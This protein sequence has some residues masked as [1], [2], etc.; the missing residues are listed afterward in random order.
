MAIPFSIAI[1]IDQKPRGVMMKYLI[2]ML[3][4]AA[5]SSKSTQL[6]KKAQNLEVY[7]NKPVDCRVSGRVVGVDKMGSK[8][9]ALND[10]LNQA[11]DLNATGLFV[12]QEV[13]NGKLM[14]V[15]ATAYQCD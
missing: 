10:A 15:H 1:I 13:P 5:C 9:L 11:A 8:E 2:P 14:N 7:A 12:N 3:I 6:S 4:L